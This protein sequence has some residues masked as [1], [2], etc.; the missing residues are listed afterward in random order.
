MAVLEEPTTLT[1]LPLTAETA[2]Q[3]LSCF[4]SLPPPGSTPAAPSVSLVA[5]LVLHA[6]SP[7]E[8]GFL[9]LA[10]DLAQPASVRAFA[11]VMTDSF[12]PWISYL[13]ASDASLMRPILASIARLV[14]A[15]KDPTADRFYMYAVTKHYASIFD[16]LVVRGFCTIDYDMWTIK[17]DAP[18]SGFA[19]EDVSLGAEWTDADGKRFKID[20][21]RTEDVAQVVAASTTGTTA[22][23]LHHIIATSKLHRTIRHIDNVPE[24]LLAPAVSWCMSHAD[25][26]VG[27]LA[28][29]PAYRARGLARRCAGSVTLSQRQGVRFP[30]GRANTLPAFAYIAPDNT[31]S[32][33]TMGKIGFVNTG[34][35]LQW[36]GVKDLSPLPGDIDGK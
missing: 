9:I 7:T 5:T 8:T 11:V 13:W 25:L 14:P 29:D 4:D 35:R 30:D 32:Q 15:Q 1:T 17:H 36:F 3:L 20:V 33:I 26:S 18:L 16:S 19:S 23:Y 34:E 27:L 12:H 6:T 28:T 21:L 24:G 31:A 22:D 10:G 2:A